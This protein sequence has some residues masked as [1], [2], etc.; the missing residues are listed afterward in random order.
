MNSTIRSPDHSVNWRLPVEP[1]VNQFLS[2]LR[3]EAAD[4]PESGIVAVFNY[5][6]EKS[7]LIPLW[8]GEGDLPTPSFI[9][10]ATTR[11]LESGQT[12]YTWQRGIPE[13]RSALSRY[14]ARVYGK[15]IPDEHFYVTGSGMQAIQIAV[16][17][18]AG[19][20][21]QV[22]VPSPVWPNI[23][24]ALGV[25]GAEPVQV[26]IDFSKNGWSL[27][28]DKIAGAVT[29]HTRALFINTPG[30][31]TGWMA[32]EDCLHDILELARKHGLWIIADEVYGRFAYGCDRAPS[33]YD[34]AGPND[35]VLYANTFSKNWAMTGW[36]MGWI[37][38]PPEIGQVLENLIQYSTSGVPEFTQRGAIEALENGE[39][40]LLSQRQKAHKNRDLLANA[41]IAT[42]KAQCAIPHGTFYLFFSVDGHLDS[43]KLAMQLVDEAKVGLAPGGAFGPGGE[44]F[45]RAC[46]LRDTDEIK[47]ATERLV[48]WL[49]NQ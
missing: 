24:A 2:S 20:G 3:P 39:S 32:D 46:F 30:N 31:P 29:A 12:F 38:A 7:D 21:D 45:L 44:P 40:F 28:I 15:K 35:R 33:F 13:L 36:R 16:Q 22:I 18:V 1:D 26:Q 6:R 37:S 4:A 41:L 8:V 25:M 5:G 23:T 27:D 19:K 48:D 42:G 49:N 11:G 9:H 17:A 43:T 34:V 14:H 10:E 47:T